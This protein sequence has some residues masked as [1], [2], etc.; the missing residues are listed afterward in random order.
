VLF[1]PATSAVATFW[2]GWFLSTG[3]AILG[4]W[5]RSIVWLVVSAVCSLPFVLIMAAY[6]PL[7]LKVFLLPIAHP[8]AA[9][10]A[11]SPRRWLTWSLLV[12]IVGL[13]GWFVL[14]RFIIAV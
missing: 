5:R 12:L 13:A 2:G 6:P 7:H 8:L 10:L 1:D 3:L 14:F 4:V 9:K 11:G